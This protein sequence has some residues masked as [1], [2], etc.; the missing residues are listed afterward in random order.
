MHA[1]TGL[2]PAGSQ[3][4]SAELESGRDGAVGTVRPELC[5][6]LLY[7]LRIAYS[8]NSAQLPLCVRTQSA[9]R[10]PRGRRR[11]WQHRAIG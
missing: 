2:A 6:H 11:P 8:S 3:Q 7:Q 1:T 4:T 10:D 5:L 9:C